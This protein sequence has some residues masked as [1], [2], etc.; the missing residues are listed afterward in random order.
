MSTALR[1]LLLIL[2]LNVVR[3]VVG[4]AIEQFTVLPPLFEA[5]A[6]S[7]SYFNTAFTS[8][9][10]ATSFLY[11]GIMW[12]VAAVVFHL[13]HP[14]LEGGWLVKSAK[15]FGLMYLFFASV[16]AIYMNH[17]SH[18]RE[19]YLYNILDGMIAFGVVALANALLYPRLLR[20]APAPLT[21]GG[22]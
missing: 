8:V 16:S 1:L 2:L 3:Y 22:V 19:F 13:M 17:Y 20:S 12:A 6:A 15:A 9:D 11:N 10:M 4:G 5:M 18:P 21:A 14:R 7:P